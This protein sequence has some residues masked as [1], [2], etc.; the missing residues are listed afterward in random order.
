[1]CF[2]SC[3]HISNVDEKLQDRWQND[4]IKST[5]FCD[6][7]EEVYNKTDEIGGQAGYFWNE[8]KA[9]VIS[10]NKYDRCVDNGLVDDILKRAQELSEENEMDI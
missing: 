8:Q 6:T 1:M 5:A 10:F 7:M 4:F 9:Q 2:V 3:S